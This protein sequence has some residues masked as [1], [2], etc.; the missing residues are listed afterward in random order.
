MNKNL[1]VEEQNMV[2]D[3]LKI[4]GNDDG[5]TKQF[6]KGLSISVIQFNLVADSIFAKCQNG[7]LTVQN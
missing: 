2:K 4:I 1:T 3:I 7:R 5:L 6:A